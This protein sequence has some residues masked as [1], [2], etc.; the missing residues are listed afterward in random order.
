VIVE[1]S[2]NGALPDP[3]WQGENKAFP[4]MSALGHK[5]TLRPS[6]AMP[7][8]PRMWRSSGRYEKNTAISLLRYLGLLF[9]LIGRS[10]LS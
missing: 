3:A 6:I 2:I 10:D 4:S 8:Y 5:R 7:L 9:L 1:V